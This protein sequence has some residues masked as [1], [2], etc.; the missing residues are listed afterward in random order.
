MQNGCRMIILEFLATS[1][2]F[3]RRL[4]A[5]EANSK[6]SSPFAGPEDYFSVSH[7]SPLHWPLQNSAC[8]GTSLC[9]LDNNTTPS[10]WVTH[11][12]MIRD[13]SDL[14]WLGPHYQRWLLSGGIQA[15]S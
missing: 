1:G 8:Q 15:L 7:Q 5:I 4:T 10:L 2:D 9:L 14:V 6:F 12:K 13:K 3:T 11:M